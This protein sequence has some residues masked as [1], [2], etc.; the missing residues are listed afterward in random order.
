MDKKLLL[1]VTFKG[2]DKLTGPIRNIIGAG[3]Q[4]AGS[5]KAMRTEAK[6]L[7]GEL[8]D[9]RRQLMAGMGN[10]API[11]ALAQRE[12]E[13]A[14][15][16]K[17]SNQRLGEQKRK[18]EGVARLRGRLNA[19][20][21][22]ASAAGGRATL[23]LTAPLLAFGAASI[24]QARESA[25][26]SAQTKASLTSMGA[27]AGRTYAQLNAQAGGLM[28]QSLFDDDEILRK[29]TAS[30]LTFGNIAGTS[31]DQAQLAAVNL[32]A[33]MDGDLQGATIMIGKALNDPIK[34]LTALSKK[35]VA[36]SDSQKEMVKSMIK[37]GNI[38]GAQAI[39][40][41]E[42][43]REF[44]GS[45]AAAR[46]ADPTAAA[47]LDVQNL[48]ESV[49][50]K[51][52]PLLI[53]VLTTVS[54][55]ADKFNALSPGT[56]SMI[57]GFAGVVAVAGP[58]IAI[59]GALATVFGVLAAVSAPVW[60]IIGAVIALG[61]AA[62]LIYTYWD[63]IKAFFV[64]LWDK[65]QSAFAGPMGTIL[66]VLFPFIGIPLMIY[67]NWDKISA[68]FSSVWTAT[69][70]I[71]TE[72]VGTFTALLAPFLYIP[73]LIYNNWGKITAFFSTV[74]EGIKTAASTGLD[75]FA[76]LPGK[77]ATFGASIIQ[78]LINA[79]SPTALVDRLLSIAKAGLTAFKN[80]FG[81]KSPSRLMMAM[82]G[83]ITHGLA[84]GL[85]RGG[86][87]PLKSM[88]RIAAGIGG[89][90]A[91][92]IASPS[93]AGSAGGSAAGSGS[94]PA[95]AARSVTYNVTIKLTST[96]D[97]K[98]DARALKRELDA[99]LAIDARGSYQD[100]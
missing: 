74:W 89:A 34:G 57:L 97:M 4:G 64:G 28:R 15:A 75:W 30:L 33:K 20:A 9:V 92:G 41:G 67:R 61:A 91:L 2:V 17:S 55:L 29:V 3:K 24:Q 68:F 96:G 71:F 69:K 52:L 22:G 77:F 81:I 88:A 85:D 94:G 82:G 26:A 1:A 53:P 39:I 83:H 62:A 56:Q 10:G 66:T 47:A 12:R 70:A 35:G 76:S 42:L 25:M 31:F 13:L 73:M 8:K 21:A 95:S 51:L 90:A 99:L 32:A 37:T 72:H 100:G 50:N 11:A 79:L 14:M 65:V 87:T 27:V 60:I 78:G 40:L 16:V 44:G 23:F 36:F 7:E 59:I 49:G 45:A 54:T 58:L 38:A 84:Q 5:L 93:F 80:F 18:I 43:K 98:V 63:P 86:K 6:A 48:Q 46:M 19:V